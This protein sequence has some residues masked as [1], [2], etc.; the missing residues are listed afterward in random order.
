[1]FNESQSTSYEFSTLASG[2]ECYAFKTHSSAAYSFDDFA[3]AWTFG[4]EAEMMKGMT[5]C[6][7]C[8]PS[9]GLLRRK[10]PVINS[11]S[12]THRTRMPRNVRLSGGFQFSLSMVAAC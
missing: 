4:N 12:T 8:K 5:P 7:T 6:D 10:V 9:S 2:D 3:G 1:M 11:M